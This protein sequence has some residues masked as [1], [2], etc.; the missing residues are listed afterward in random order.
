M[1]SRTSRVVRTPATTRTEEIPAEYSTITKR[2]IK[3]PATTREEVIPAEFKTVTRRV[4]RTPATTTT[5]V[6]P[7]EYQTVTRRVVKTPASTRSIDVPAEFT[8]VTKRQLIRKG[9]FTEWR[10][11]V[12]GSDVTTQMVRDVQNALR[13]RGFDPGPADNVMGAKTKAALVKFQRENNLPVGQ[14]DF[15]TLRALGVDY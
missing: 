2:V 11:I 9:G 10:E 4:L 3:T 13:T 5:E 8:T 15:E 14:L 6:I 7:A 12:C 1:G